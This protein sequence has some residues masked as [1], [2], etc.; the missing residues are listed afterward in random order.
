[1]I[2]IDF[3]NTIVCYDEVFRRTAVEQGLV[4]PE[5]A[6]S[7][8]AIRDHLRAAGR[9]DRWTELQ[10]AVYGPRMLEAHPFPGVIEFFTACRAARIPVVIVSQRTRFPYLGPQH[11]L[12]AAARDWLTHHD[13]HDPAGIDLP[14]NRV[15]FEETKEAKLARI[16]AVGC[17]YF[18]DDLPELLT[19]PHFPDGVRRILFD[20]NG[21]YHDVSGVDVAQSWPHLLA[22][23]VGPAQRLFGGGN[24][25]VSRI[26]TASGPMLLKEYFRHADDPRDRLAA[27]QAFSQFAWSHGVHAV[28]QPLAYSARAGIG[29]CEFISGQPLVP[30]AVTAAHIDE[31]AEFLAN[32]NRHRHTAEAARLPVA[33]EACFTHREHLACVDRRLTKLGGIAPASDLHRKAAEIV[34]DRLVPAWSSVRAR[35]AAGIAAPDATLSAA[36]RV[37]SPS[38]FGFHNCIATPAGLKFIDFEYAGWD[39]PAKTVGDFF[40]QPAVPAPR[41]HVERFVTTVAKV[42]GGG[43]ALLERVVLL[44]PVYELK[45]CCIMLNEFLPDGYDRRAF[46]RG[47]DARAV[48]LV[49]QLQ[50]VETALAR[51]DS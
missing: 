42:L 17:T 37:I 45:W 49:D 25:R 33:S 22:R 43:D 2:G 24:N 32:V 16:A 19:H 44:L 9:E 6:T 51:I 15:F 47:E 13:F 12:H 14:V 21:R 31:A 30:G 1:V 46:A 10:G 36:D 39:D 8:T 20:P 50:K 18:I 26:D 35:A 34:A 7:K 3:D 29:F 23:F 48:T 5:A 27:E 28:P 4:P 41:E 38:D 40:C 11:N